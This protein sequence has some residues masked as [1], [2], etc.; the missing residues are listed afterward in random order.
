MRKIYLFIIISVLIITFLG[1]TLIY[2]NSKITKDIN[3]NNPETKYIDKVCNVCN[4][5]TDI[6]TNTTKKVCTM[7]R[8]VYERQ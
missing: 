8:C 7:K 4:E 5:I 6:N 2:N 3:K 1:Y